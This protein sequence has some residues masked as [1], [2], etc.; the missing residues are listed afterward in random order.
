MVLG[1]SYMSHI[2]HNGQFLN[3]Y[4]FTVSLRVKHARFPLL[5]CRSGGRTKPAPAL[6]IPVPYFVPLVRKILK[7]VIKYSTQK[8]MLG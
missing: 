8:C 1:N 2:H 5:C 7:G 3:I 6:F 4:S